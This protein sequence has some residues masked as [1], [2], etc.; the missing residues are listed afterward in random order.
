VQAAEA[1]WLGRHEAFEAAIDKAMP[2][3]LDISEFVRKATV[4]TGADRS[5]IMWRADV[6]KQSMPVQAYFSM[7]K[8]SMETEIVATEAASR[9]IESINKLDAAAKK[10]REAVKNDLTSMKAS[11]DRVQSEVAQMEGRYKQATQILNSADFERALVNAERMA[12][13]LEA[14]SKLSE[15]KLSVAV[16]GG[17]KQ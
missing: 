16:F 17:G 7:W 10:F 12:S 15:T 8:A 11:S 1:F 14:I 4:K 9:A 2:S 13:A 6:L 3:A 5:G